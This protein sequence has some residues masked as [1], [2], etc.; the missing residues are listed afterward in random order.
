MFLLLTCAV[1]AQAVDVYVQPTLTQGLRYSYA[2]E[3]RLHVLHYSAS[4]SVGAAFVIDSFII[5]PQ[6][7]F[8][9]APPPA[10]DEELLL[11]FRGDVGMGIG[12]YGAYIVSPRLTLGAEA[13]LDFQFFWHTW[14]LFASPTLG[15]FAQFPL[16]YYDQNPGIAMRLFTNLHFRRDTDFTIQAGAAVTLYL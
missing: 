16:R 5:S 9:L 8:S 7:R 10:A 6:A 11:G 3:Y 12:L 2:E 13:A 1:S 14:V 15:V 4:L